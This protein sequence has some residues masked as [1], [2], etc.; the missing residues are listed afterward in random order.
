MKMIFNRM[1]KCRL[2]DE[3]F[4]PDKHREFLKRIAPAGTFDGQKV[5]ATLCNHKSWVDD[6]ND[7]M[8]IRE[9]CSK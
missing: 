6:S 2:C 9:K 7:D 3:Y 1:L 4:D 8:A 5:I